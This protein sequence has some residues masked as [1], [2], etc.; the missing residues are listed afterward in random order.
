METLQKWFGQI[1]DFLDI[2][3]FKLGEAQLTLWTLLYLVVLLILLFY[4]T[5]KLKRWIVERLLAK[6]SIDIGVRQAVGSIV[7][8]IVVLIGFVIILQKAGIDL[9]ALTI[10]AGALGIGVGFGLQNIRRQ[11]T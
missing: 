7:R 11:A 9:S 4:L 3:I 1:K 6:S 10:L 5:G 8:Y 2:P